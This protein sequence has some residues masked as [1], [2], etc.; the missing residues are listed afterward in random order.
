M[1]KATG[2]LFRLMLAGVLFL[3]A[4]SLSSPAAMLVGV[5]YDSGTLYEIS[6]NNA[7]STNDV[8]LSFIGNTGITKLGCLEFAQDGF[9]YAFDV[10]QEEFSS[11]YRIDPESAQ[12][13]N[14]AIL[15]EFVYEGGLAIASDG[16]VYGVNAGRNENPLLFKLDLLTGLV[17][18]ITNISGGKH[19]INGLAWR[20]DEMLVGLD[21]VSN[22]IVAIN[23]TN[24]VTSTIT[25]L[26]IDV[27]AVGGMAVLNGTGYFSTAGPITGSNELYAFDLFSG[28]YRWI[29]KFPTNFIADCS[30][31]V[32]RGEGISGLAVVPDSPI[33]SSPRLSIA[34]L[35]STQLEVTWQKKLYVEYALEV[36]SNPSTAAW[37]AV[38]NCA[39]VCGDFVS[40]VVE[41]DSQRRF[42]RLRR[43]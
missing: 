12:N 13:T 7:S 40:V 32:I 16:T 9:L 4:F 34:L 27:G 29:G 20:S 11:L 42:F 23:P 31:N 6:T 19:D 41:R 8:S 14:I 30:T 43:L 15:S 24:G 3:A 17:T 2:N 36:A 38:T 37:T 22:S 10:E 1:A 35:S 21:R 18:V 26:D 39:S 33:T 28:A 25:N 5:D